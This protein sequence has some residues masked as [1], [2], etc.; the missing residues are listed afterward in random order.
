[1]VVFNSG[2]LKLKPPLFFKYPSQR[3]KYFV[4]LRKRFYFYFSA[5]FISIYFILF[6]ICNY[7]VSIYIIFCLIVIIFFIFI[8]VYCVHMYLGPE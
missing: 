4:F 3:E 2:T 8:G 1:M 6:V 5:L 7:F